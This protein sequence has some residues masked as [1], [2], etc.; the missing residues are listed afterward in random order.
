MQVNTSTSKKWT[1]CGNVND[2]LEILSYPLITLP[3]KGNQRVNLPKTWCV[4]LK[5]NLSA[6][7]CW[8]K[9][10]SFLRQWRVTT[11][12]PSLLTSWLTI[13]WVGL[14]GRAPRNVTPSFNFTLWRKKRHVY[15]CI[16]RKDSLTTQ[17]LI[18]VSH[19]LY[20]ADPC[21][22]AASRQTMIFFFW[23]F[24]PAIHYPDGS[25]HCLAI[26]RCPSCYLGFDHTVFLS[27]EE[28]WLF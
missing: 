27:Q 21:M 28:N 4:P 14:L 6:D 26:K 18:P 25:L 7:L 5:W 20:P 8:S 22:A 9:L 23:S 11:R 19:W 1:Q 13:H 2:L 15:E 3:R 10:D 24:C 16:R 17:I 12:W